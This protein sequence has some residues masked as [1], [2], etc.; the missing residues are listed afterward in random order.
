MAT[1]NPGHSGGAYLVR[2]STFLT[3]SGRI[4]AH[5]HGF[6]QDVTCLDGNGAIA[7]VTTLPV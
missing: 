3:G 5:H 1:E 6:V 4:N 7:Q 2:H